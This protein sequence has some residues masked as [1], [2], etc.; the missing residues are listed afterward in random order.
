MITTDEVKTY[1]RI[2]YNDDDTLI[3]QMI[4][5]GYNYLE[6]AVDDFNELYDDN[7]KGFADM[8]DLWVKTQWMP[9]FYDQRE[10][11]LTDKQND[12]TF[13][14][15]SMITQLQTYERKEEE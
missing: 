8:C 15:R 1:L 3:S 2:P 14:A 4:S 11:M 6:N 12:L 7:Y 10:G 13:I 5:Q 9:T